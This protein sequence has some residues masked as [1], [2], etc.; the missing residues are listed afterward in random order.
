VERAVAA[1]SPYSRMIPQ[2]LGHALG[3]WDPLD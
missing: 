1:R 3:A 2:M